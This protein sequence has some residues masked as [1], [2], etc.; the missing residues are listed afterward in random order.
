MPWPTITTSKLT[1]VRWF[2]GSTLLILGIAAY[3]VTRFLDGFELW[4]VPLLLAA[5]G[6]FLGGIVVITHG[7]T[8]FPKHEPEISDPSHVRQKDDA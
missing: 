6:C 4:H 8:H 2:I 1:P 3:V 7:A 5:L